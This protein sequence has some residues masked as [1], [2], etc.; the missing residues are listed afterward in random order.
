MRLWVTLFMEINDM[1]LL[2]AITITV[3]SLISVPASA[4]S[5]TGLVNTGASFTAGQ[6]DTNYSFASLGGTATGTGGYGVVAPDT[7]FPIGPWIANTSASKWLAPTSNAAQS[8]DPVVDGNYKWT[9]SFDLTGYIP[10]T[11]SFAGRW[12]AD[13]GGTVKLNGN[14][15]GSSSGFTTFSSFSAN[16]GFVGG[17]N[18]LDF[19]VTNYARDGGNPTGLRVEFLQSSVTP[20]PEPET[21]ALLLA[22]LGLMGTIARRRKNSPV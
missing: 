2:P 22:G 13:N 18:T 7:G 21:Y 17:I 19:Y 20:V 3:A 9:L 11:A 4:A 10:N 15:L 16:S 5:I 1:R 12:A 8:Y 6:T 14:L